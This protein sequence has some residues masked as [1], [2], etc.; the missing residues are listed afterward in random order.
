MQ[1]SAIYLYPIKSLA[2]IRLEKSK[3]TL[4]GLENDR[5][6]MLTKLDGTF[7]TQRV[8][9]QMA[10]LKVKIA[11]EELHIWHKEQ[12][13]DV[14]IIPI[15]PAVFIGTQATDV[16]G[17]PCKGSILEKSINDW[18]SQKLNTPCQLI[19]MTEDSL[20]PIDEAYRKTGEIVSFA[21][22]FP[23]LLL[24]QASMDD[25]NSRLEQ[26]VDINRFRANLIFSGGQPFEEDH[27]NYFKIGD[28]TFRGTK[29]CARCQ[30]PNIN[31]E[32]AAIEQEPN[33][34]LAR[35]RVFKRNGKNK[36]LFGMNACWEQGLSEGKH[37]L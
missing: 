3:V 35:F 25:L 30:V 21:D 6:F 33:R 23:Y 9:P 27:W 19:Y 32:T 26:P 8:I 28:L 18:F 36:V 29:P 10:L 7:L 22:G 31:Q 16:W 24:G 13:T 2:G 4:R 34:T 20:R 17:H 14:L 1:L 11:G 12:P 5:R 15:K 37:R